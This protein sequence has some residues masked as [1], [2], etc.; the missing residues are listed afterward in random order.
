MVVATLY[1][2][3]SVT[4]SAPL[5]YFRIESPVIRRAIVEVTNAPD[6]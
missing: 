6:V 5:V 1:I 2:C 4:F 3:A